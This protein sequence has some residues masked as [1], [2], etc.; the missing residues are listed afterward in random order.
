METL[1]S[2]SLEVRCSF[3]H[4]QLNFKVLFNLLPLSLHLE[5]PLTM[6]KGYYESRIT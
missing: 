1:K 5:T 4:Q 2:A 6:V 3:S